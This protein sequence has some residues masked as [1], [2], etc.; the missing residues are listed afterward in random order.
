MLATLSV[1]NALLLVLV[2]LAANAGLAQHA[3]LDV[4]STTSTTSTS[5]TPCAEGQGSTG[6]NI[7]L[8]R[9]LLGL[10][11]QEQLFGAYTSY[12]ASPLLSPYPRP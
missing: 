12:W 9:Y 8:T 5:P 7:T 1:V 3:P 2:A 11:F 10:S 6:G 4:T